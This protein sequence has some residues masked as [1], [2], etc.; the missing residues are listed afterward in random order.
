MTRKT[1]FELDQLILPCIC[2][3]MQMSLMVDV[4]TKYVMLFQ[5]TSFVFVILTKNYRIDKVYQMLLQYGDVT[6]YLFTVKS[7]FSLLLALEEQFELECKSIIN[8][9]VKNVTWR[10]NTSLLMAAASSIS[11]IWFY[12]R[13]AHLF[14]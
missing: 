5:H 4:N 6:F 8:T 12:S 2:K 10:T 7:H 9:F 14:N 11:T 1:R 3:N 13:F